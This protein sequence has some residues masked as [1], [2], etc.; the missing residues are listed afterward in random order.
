VVNLR[1]PREIDDRERVSFDGQALLVEL[2]LAG[3]LD[4]ELTGIEA[5]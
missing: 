4:R 5:R 2:P 1:T 3:L